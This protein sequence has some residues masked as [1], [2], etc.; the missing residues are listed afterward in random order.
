MDKITI[1]QVGRA[2]FDIDNPNKMSTS[3]LPSI[4]IHQQLAINLEDDK[5]FVKQSS[6]KSKFDIVALRSILRDNTWP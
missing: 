2:F 5:T 1:T 4:N 3:H 6:S